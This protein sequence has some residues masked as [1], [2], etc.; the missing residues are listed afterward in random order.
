MTNKDY[1]KTPLEELKNTIHCADCLTF[2]KD[3]PDKSV[4]LILTDPPYGMN[5]QSSRKTATP[6]FKKIENDINIDWFPKF[7]KECYRVLKD[8]SHIYI[9]CND[10]NISK[11]RDLQEQAGFKNKRTLVWVKNNHTSGDLLGD[12][13]NKTE[14]IN[15]A[16]KGR[17]LLNGG[18]DTNVLNFSRVSKLEHPTQKPVDL[19]EYLIK[20]STNEGDTILDPFAGSGTTGVAC[21]NLNRNFILIEKEPE[22]IDIIKK[23]LDI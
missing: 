17:R 20:K 22:Y 10:Y 11:F 9:F 15:Y 21:K 19:N 1:T 7:I 6:Q 3:I 13:A 23:R 16:Q 12:Y 2:M 5:Y 18:R 4:D 14:F 8:N